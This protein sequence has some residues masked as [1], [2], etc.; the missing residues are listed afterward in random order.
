MLHQRL[1]TL[2]FKET[3]CFQ[4]HVRKQEGIFGEFSY[5]REPLDEPVQTVA[6]F[7]SLLPS[8]LHLISYLEIKGD[9]SFESAVHDI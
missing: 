9:K 3:E 4:K 5:S 8:F 2:K 7:K 6:L 1:D